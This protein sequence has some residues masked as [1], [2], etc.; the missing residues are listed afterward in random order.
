MTPG[1]EI[2]GAGEWPGFDRSAKLERP[3]GLRQCR[4][5]RRSGVGAAMSVN[6]VRTWAIEF[7]QTRQ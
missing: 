6:Q 7:D 5:L 4:A 1:A 3:T 2:A